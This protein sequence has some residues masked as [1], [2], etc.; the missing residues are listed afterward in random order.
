MR[1]QPLKS[2]RDNL[3]QKRIKLTDETRIIVDFQLILNFP[4]GKI[5]IK[6]RPANARINLVF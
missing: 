1:L 2:N 4:I 3:R 5:V 6:P